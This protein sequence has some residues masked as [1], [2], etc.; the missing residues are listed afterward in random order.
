M[1][2]IVSNRNVNEGV[3]DHTVFG[4]QTNMRGINELRVAT[5][6][7]DANTSQWNV[8][9][10]PE[11]NDDNNPPS[12]MLFEQVTALVRSGDLNERWVFYIHGFN[13][14]FEQNLETCLDLK[15]NYDINVITFSWPSNPG[16]IVFSEYRKA[17]LAAQ[18][19]SSALDRTLEKMEQY[20]LS[21]STEEIMSCNISINLLIHSLGNYLVES[22]IRSP[23]FSG[24]TRIFD[25][26]IFH[27]A[28]IDNRKHTEWIDGVEHGQRIYVTIN[29][30]DSI[31]R[32]SDIINPARLGNTVEGLTA[33]MP[34]YID[35]TGGEHVGG[36]H[37]FF[38]PRSE[39]QIIA[40]FFQQ[41]LTGKHGERI[42]GFEF[43]SRTN[44]F[45]LAENEGR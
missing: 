15:E 41:V 13:Q 26:I 27:Q 39:N 18:A 16:G 34:L 25:N 1:I 14:S 5:A 32:K 33:T 17:R 12:R 28:D 43:D 8:N 31:L 44:T 19:S 37:N 36:S 40:E 3:T 11:T 23:V 20:L 30:F 10:L 35:F 6:S 2:I 22:F 38:Q 9:L 42:P 29:E 24:E 7:Y 21:R 45:R 4:E